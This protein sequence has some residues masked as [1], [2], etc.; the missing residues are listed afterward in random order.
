MV[1]KRIVS[2]SSYVDPSK[3]GQTQAAGTREVYQGTFEAQWTCS[4]CGRTG[5]PGR[6]KRCPSCN[7]PKDA[8]E[9]YEAPTGKVSYLT[10]DELKAMGVDPTQHLSDEEC[11]YCGAKLR[12][13]TQK[14]P[15]CGAILGDVGYT[16]RV[17]PACGRESNA[18]KCPACG[19]ET[20]D[21]L[22][23]HR[24]AEPP[25]AARSNWLSSLLKTPKLL[26]PLLLILGLMCF[27]VVSGI[28]A[29]IP[30]TEAATVTDIAWERSIVIQEYRYVERSDWSLPAGADLIS[31]EERIASYDKVQVGTEEK[32]GYEENCTTESVY[33]HTERTCYD[34]GTC[35]EH[36]V[37]RDE[38]TCT[39]EYVCEQ[40]PVYESV[41]VYA[42]WYTY[43][44]WEWVDLEPIV[45]RGSDIDIYWP[46]TRLSERQNERSRTENCTVT[47]TTEKG[48][49]Y[50]YQP[51]C[52]E[53]HNYPRGSRWT[54]KRNLTEIL[55]IHPIEE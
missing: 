7:N 37:Y 31:Q 54:I 27:C 15:N 34:D 25:P 1:K 39:N 19:A 38:Q 2:Q 50:L 36:D 8:G 52:S 42:T 46:E 9:Q 6:L 4:S 55:E 13:G 41:P 14:C 32:C 29:G 11:D 24:E 17:C 23:A 12:P 22:V 10:P 49:S 16:T 44:V 35:D 47:F 40:V 48:E 28:I 33:D 21:K 43:N 26:I 20:E 5:I 53:L 3:V 18:E 45:E 51:P 30:K